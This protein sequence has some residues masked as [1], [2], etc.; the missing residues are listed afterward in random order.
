[1]LSAHPGYQSGPREIV[2]TLLNGGDDRE[3]LAE[4]FLEI[5]GYGL[6]LH[7]GSG[8]MRQRP[9]KHREH[10]DALLEDG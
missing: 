1:V 4:F 9:A 10:C 3:R 6:A 5:C 2:C 8:G 7:N